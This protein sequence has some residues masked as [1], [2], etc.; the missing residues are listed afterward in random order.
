MRRQQWYGRKGDDASIDK[1]AHAQEEQQEQQEDPQQ[2]DDI[3][4]VN[5]LHNGVQALI[6]VAQLMVQ[7][8]KA[9][10]PLA[11]VPPPIPM[12]PFLKVQVSLP[13]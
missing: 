13:L 11:A 2:Q 6:Q 5:N 9:L 1:Q 4:V 12:G 8:S 7:A 10:P 3:Q